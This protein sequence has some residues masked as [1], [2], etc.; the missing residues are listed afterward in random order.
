VRLEGRGHDPEAEL[1][2]A[3][4]EWNAHVEEDGRIVPDIARL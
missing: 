3:F 2:G 1:E 4:T